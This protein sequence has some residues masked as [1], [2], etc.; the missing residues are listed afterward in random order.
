MPGRS[1][2]SIED[3]ARKLMEQGYPPAAAV[4]MAHSTQDREHRATLIQTTLDASR[5]LK[6]KKSKRMKPTG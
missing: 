2:E 4:A 5:N 3:R 6:R 1:I